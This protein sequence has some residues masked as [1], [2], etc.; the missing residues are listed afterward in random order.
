MSWLSGSLVKKLK[1]EDEE[2]EKQKDIQLCL[3]L[4]ILLGQQTHDYYYKQYHQRLYELGIIETDMGY[5]FGTWKAFERAKY[6]LACQQNKDT[7]K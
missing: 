7:D 5:R 4:G 2:Q 1:I 6:E 3:Q